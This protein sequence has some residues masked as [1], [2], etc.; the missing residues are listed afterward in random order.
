MA[1]NER[2]KRNRRDD[3]AGGEIAGEMLKLVGRF[4]LDFGRLSGK[5]LW[6]A[7]RAIS[8]GEGRR[9]DGAPTTDEPNMAVKLYRLATHRARGGQAET[10][11]ARPDDTAHEAPAER[12]RAT[13]NND[14]GYLDR[15]AVQDEEAAALLEDLLRETDADLRRNTAPSTSAPPGDTPTTVEAAGP[16]PPPTPPTPQPTE[17]E[18]AEAAL[19]S[20]EEQLRQRAEALKAQQHLHPDAPDDAD[21]APAITYNTPEEKARIEANLRQQEALREQER[22][23]REAQAAAEDAEREQLRAAMQADLARLRAEQEARAARFT[24][25]ER[26]RKRREQEREA[27]IRGGRL[28]DNAP[29][30]DTDT[31]DTPPTQQT[32]HN[33]D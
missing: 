11:P 2:D 7:Y 14:A 10:P 9:A 30:T 27:A 31:T 23:T 13:A 26:E 12:K 24:A 17:G 16:P 3:D 33:E 5:A 22:R 6:R 4:L 19:L 1:D 8:R 20:V 18:Q 21:E 25:A 15:S 29:P 28:A 32:T